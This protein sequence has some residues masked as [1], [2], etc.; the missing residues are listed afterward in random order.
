MVVA[1]C[2]TSRKQIECKVAD[3]FGGRGLRNRVI[4]KPSD[5]H[6]HIVYIIINKGTGVCVRLKR[7]VLV[8]RHRE[9]DDMI[10]HMVRDQHAKPSV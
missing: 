3:G 2:L 4:G 1:Q 9:R 5:V 6:V 10:L 7:I 8:R